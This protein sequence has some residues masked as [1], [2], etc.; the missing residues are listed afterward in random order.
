MLICRTFE[1]AK[2]KTNF[3]FFFQKK[4]ESKLLLTQ[5]KKGRQLKVGWLAQG[6]EAN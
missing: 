4:S 3:F 6:C 1:L 2:K 5:V